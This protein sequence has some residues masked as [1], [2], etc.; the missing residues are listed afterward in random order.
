MILIVENGKENKVQNIRN[1]MTS[2]VLMVTH[3]LIS[4]QWHV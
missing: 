4:V 1:K 3:E 2:A